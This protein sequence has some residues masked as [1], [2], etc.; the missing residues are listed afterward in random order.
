MLV[1]LVTI[2]T[3]PYGWISDEVVLLPAVLSVVLSAP[4]KFSME[5]LIVLNCAA[6]LAFCVTVQARAW[7][8]L[9][10]FAW[11]LYAVRPEVNRSSEGN[12]SDT[13]RQDVSPRFS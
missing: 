6:L 13:G 7:L 2:L 4:R 10:W 3:S 11:Y 12:D 8:P 5:I 9:V 1:I